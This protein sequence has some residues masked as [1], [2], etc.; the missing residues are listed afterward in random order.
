VQSV[1][2]SEHIWSHFKSYCRK[3]GENDNEA[4]IVYEPVGKGS[5]GTK[6]KKTEL[7]ISRVVKG[8]IIVSAYR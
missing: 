2:S 4:Y 7:P 3:F 1:N 5:A 8:T 6:S